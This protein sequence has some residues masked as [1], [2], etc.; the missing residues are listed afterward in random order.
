METGANYK[1]MVGVAWQREP[2]DRAGYWLWIEKRGNEGEVFQVGICEAGLAV[3]PGPFW[4]CSQ[5][6]DLVVLSWCSRL[7]DSCRSLVT[8]PTDIWA[9][10]RVEL[11]EAEAV[12][13][14][15]PADSLAALEADYRIL[16]A[17]RGWAQMKR[18]AFYKAL[19]GIW[20]ERVE[21]ARLMGPLAVWYEPGDYAAAAEKAKVNHAV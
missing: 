14:E 19:F 16:V 21:A 12:D 10:A 15:G 2:P 3:G 5:L 18:E 8:G 17:A 13:S 1:L 7:P 20:G 11:P 9:W 4:I 6:H